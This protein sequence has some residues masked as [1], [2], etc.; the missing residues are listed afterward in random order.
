[1]KKIKAKQHID[2]SKN[3][4]IPTPPGE[5]STFKDTSGQNLQSKRR[6]VGEALIHSCRL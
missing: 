5:Y 3:I 6:T 4:V 2:L 1:M